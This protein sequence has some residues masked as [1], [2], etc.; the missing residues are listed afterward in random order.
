MLPTIWLFCLVTSRLRQ[1]IES[2]YSAPTRRSKKRRTVAGWH[3]AGEAALI[4]FAILTP[5]KVAQTAHSHGRRQRVLGD[6]V[7]ARN[8]ARVGR[9][10]H[11]LRFLETQSF[12]PA[13]GAVVRLRQRLAIHR[14]VLVVVHDDVPRQ[15]DHSLDVVDRWIARVA[16]Y[17]DIAVLRR[18][19]R[20]DLLL[21]DRQAD[22]VDELVDED[23]VADLER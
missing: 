9:L 22:A 23:E 17:D 19:D 10:Q 3:P 11:L 14:Q 7:R 8:A 4:V 18:A 20:D 6:C 21:D 16:E 5:G 12:Q 13:V 2:M 1:S 15:P